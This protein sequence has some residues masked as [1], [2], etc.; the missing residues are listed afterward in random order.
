MRQ[1]SFRIFDADQKLTLAATNSGPNGKLIWQKGN[2][3]H[4]LDLPQGTQD[5]LEDC[6]CGGKAQWHSHALET[7]F[8]IKCSKAACPASVQAQGSG[9][10]VERWNAMQTKT[11]W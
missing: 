11:G 2:G 6:A 8:V 7:G 5:A 4:R 1:C 3:K 9:E 10:A